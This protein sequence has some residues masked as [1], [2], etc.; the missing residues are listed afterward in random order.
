MHQL[1]SLIYEAAGETPNNDAHNILTQIHQAARRFPA[2]QRDLLEHASLRGQQRHDTGTTPY[3][4]GIQRLQQAQKDTHQPTWHQHSCLWEIFDP[5]ITTITVNTSK[6][7]PTT[8]SKQKLHPQRKHIP[9]NYGLA[10]HR[11][12][13]TPPEIKES[14]LI[15]HMPQTCERMLGIPCHDNIC[16]SHATPKASRHTTKNK[17]TPTRP[18]HHT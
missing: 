2:K 18:P 17:I 14:F 7:D 8:Y 16:P 12:T 10:Q 1:T 11:D 3:H 5:H 9:P 13:L 4:K 6:A 15:N